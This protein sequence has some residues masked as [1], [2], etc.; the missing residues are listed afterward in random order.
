PDQFAATFSEELYQHLLSGEPVGEALLATR[1]HFWTRYRNPLG[2]AY[3]LYS[4]PS[5]R[6]V[7]AN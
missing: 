3:A 5:V 4:S 2:L 7:H 6:I 1:N